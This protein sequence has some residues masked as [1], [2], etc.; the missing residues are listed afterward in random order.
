[1]RK[2]ECVCVCLSGCKKQQGWR[3][4]CE[5]HWLLFKDAFYEAKSLF[6]ELCSVISGIY[7][8]GNQ[9]LRW[10]EFIIRPSSWEWHETFSAH[11]IIA[12]IC[13]ERL[14]NCCCAWL[15]RCWFSSFFFPPSPKLNDKNSA[16]II[17][18]I[19][20]PFQTFFPASL[21]LPSHHIPGRNDA[22]CFSV[23]Y[24]DSPAPTSTHQHH[25]FIL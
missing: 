18:R 25:R 21:S 12:F 7:S 19:K 24:A 20:I 5:W 10:V 14:L 13:T 6:K 8:D 17:F 2:I 1:M 11:F 16:L 4:W 9:A 3:W 15:M 23:V 22:M